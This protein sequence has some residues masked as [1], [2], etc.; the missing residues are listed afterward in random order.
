MRSGLFLAPIAVAPLALVAA[1]APQEPPTS[2]PLPL[3]PTCF[4]NPGGKDLS[5]GGTPD[6][7][8]NVRVTPR[9]DGSC[10]GVDPSFFVVCSRSCPL[11][12]N[13]RRATSA[14]S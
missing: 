5:Y 10:S 11:Q 1:C 6:R 13:K 9:T 3:G 2:T 12:T 8:G 14:S 4:T 7:L